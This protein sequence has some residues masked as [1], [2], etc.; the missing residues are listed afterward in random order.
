MDTPADYTLAHQFMDTNFLPDTRTQLCMLP[1][2]SVDNTQLVKVGLPTVVD[3]LASRLSNEEYW[4]CWRSIRNNRFMKSYELCNICNIREANYFQPPEDLQLLMPS[5]SRARLENACWRA[6]GKKL[7][8]LKEVDPATINW[9]KINDNTWLYGPVL[10]ADS[11]MELESTACTPCSSWEGTNL[12]SCMKSNTN[13]R[14]GR[15]I[16][17]NSQV[18]VHLVQ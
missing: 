3:Y 6:W 8:S 10:T 1:M 13:T 11:D 15:R 9:D 5:T 17:F 18:E 14:P 12:K 16:S 2:I 7:G 4:N